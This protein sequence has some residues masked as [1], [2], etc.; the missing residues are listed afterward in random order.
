MFLMKP[1]TAEDRRP[2]GV[3]CEQPRLDGS[4]WKTMQEVKWVAVIY[5]L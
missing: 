4:E 2:D 3:I 5:A 1:E